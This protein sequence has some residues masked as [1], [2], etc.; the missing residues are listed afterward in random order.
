MKFNLEFDMDNE[1]FKPYNGDEVVRI[2]EAINKRI[3]A[4][5][6]ET[7]YTNTVIIFDINGN[8]IGKL[9]ITE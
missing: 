3:Y 4:S 6:I 8:R 1:A 5:T 7:D 9:E 2:L